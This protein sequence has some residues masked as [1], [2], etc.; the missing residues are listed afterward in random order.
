MVAKGSAAKARAGTTV[1]NVEVARIF[2]E[3]ADLLEIQGA[4]PFRLRA[5]RNAARSI[6]ELPESVDAIARSDPDRLCE[7]P[8]IGKNLAGKI[9]EIVT[10]GT[11]AA[12]REVSRELPRG[13][14]TLMGVRG[15][16][17][18]RARAL[19]DGLGIHTLKQLERAARAGRIRD[20]A[21]FGEKT[22]QHI[23]QELAARSP[24]EQRVLRSVAAQYGETYLTYL[25]A[26]PGVL[27][28]EIAG[29]YRRCRETVGDLDILA[30][31]KPRTPLVGHFVGYPEVEEVMAQG[32][33]KAS[34]RLRGGVQVDLRVLDQESYGAGLYYFTGSKAHNIAVR[35]IG[36]KLGLKVNEYGVFRG[37]R[38][39]AGRTEADVFRVVGLPWI[40]PELREDRGE[41]DAARTGMLPRLVEL[42]DIRGDVQMHTTAS[43]GRNTLEEMVEAV[44]TLGYEYLAIT[45]HSPAL[46]MVQGLDRDGFRAQMK[47]IERLNARLRH[48]TIL[49]AGEIDILAHGALDLD[50]ETLAEMDLVV[51][52]IHSGFDLPEPKQTERVLRAL[53]H[54]SVDILGHPTGRILNRRS[55]IA[56][57]LERVLRA[58]AERGIMLEVNAQPDRLDLDDVSVRAAIEVGVRLVISS[59]AHAAAELRFMRWGV[60]QARRG[61][62][63]KEDIANTLPFREF[64]KLLHARR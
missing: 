55:P 28:A 1:E 29:S 24:G 11:L 39:I 59:D 57:D 8:G 41:I 61:W 14:T 56:L 60:D 9:V 6:E 53:D 34:V 62:A 42:G 18:K 17:A 22:E 35:R 58:A 37:K 45:D 44:R 7:L 31:V 63:R 23:L 64:R 12:L 48:V 49:R 4:N 33:T 13:L 27:Q 32:P 25:R 38:R 15:L 54:R 36:Q 10:S 20:L 5:Y 26:L 30:S 52:S 2:R 40:P 51:V 50:D 21:G 47:H 19:Y 16:G 46:R 43:D 3:L